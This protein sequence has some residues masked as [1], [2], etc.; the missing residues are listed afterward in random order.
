MKILI[1]GI[2][3]FIGSRLAKRLKEN[4][5]ISCLTRNA[6]KAKKTLKFP[7]LIHEWQNIRTPPPCQAFEN[8]S[9]IINLAGESVIKKRWSESQKEKLIESRVEYTRQLVQM[10]QKYNSIHT[11]INAS[12]T[13]FYGHRED[14]VLDENS[15]QGRGFLPHLCANWEK[16]ARLFENQKD[17]R[18]VIFR[19]GN[20]LSRKGGMI[21]K[22]TP[23]FKLG[24]GC[25]FSHGQQWMSWIHINDLLR[26]FTQ[27]LENKNWQ[28]TFNAVSPHPIT[29]Q[30]WTVA[31]S[32][33]LHRPAFFKIP[34]FA[35]RL[36]LGEVSQLFLN[37]QR[38]IPKQ[39]QKKGFIFDFPQIESS[40]KNIFK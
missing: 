7:C 27:A 28:G 10:A 13:G 3:G 26:L 22:L 30:E 36:T 1:T 12:A 2:T 16:S 25:T 8:V 6:E 38:V 40:L 33:T 11:L 9:A 4:H 5:E 18:V 24:L 31:F 35:L 37:S 17:R 34:D 14:E 19:I 21:S 32:K 29:Y 15:P 20:V 39:A 23:L